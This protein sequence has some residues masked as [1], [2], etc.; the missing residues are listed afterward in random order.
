M[1]SGCLTLKVI[2]MAQVQN[3]LPADTQCDHCAVRHKSVCGALSADELIR[4]NK[5]ASTRKME[6]GE[7]ILS[8]EVDVTFFANIVSGVVK[9]TKMLP[10]GRQQLI[11]LQFPSDFLGRAYGKANPYFA[12]AVT[13]VE[14]CCFK[15]DPF[16][17]LLQDY[18]ALERRLF[19]NTLDELDAARE[20]LLLLGRKSAV[21]KVASFLLMLVRRASLVGCARFNPGSS[22]VIELPL[23]RADIADFLGLTIE[24]VSRQ[25]AALK[26]EGAVDF[27]DSRHCEIVDSALLSSLA[28]QDRPTLD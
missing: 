18:P 2:I 21:E 23:G 7:T 16:E 13:D 22:A 20:W 14:L 10:D 17:E 5:I 1:G 15:Q 9:L 19:E 6:A 24:T 4:L 3:T 11:G 25:F 8:D 27:R 26:A 12:E 28:G